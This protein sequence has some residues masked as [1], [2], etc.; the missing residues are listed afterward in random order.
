MKRLYKNVLVVFAQILFLLGFA[1]NTSADGNRDTMCSNDS[2]ANWG[3][4]KHNTEGEHYCD[5]DSNFLL[6]CDGDIDMNS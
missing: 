2:V 4:C 5:G 6:D 3:K 1:T